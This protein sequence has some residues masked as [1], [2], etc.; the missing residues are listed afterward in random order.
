[1][2]L[3][4]SSRLV[5]F[6]KLNIGILDD[7]QNKKKLILNLNKLITKIYCFLTL[8]IFCYSLMEK[9]I[10]KPFRFMSDICQNK[11]ALRVNNI[12]S[13]CHTF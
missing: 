1:M 6:Q 3:I 9:K 13:Q 11:I 4:V 10:K 8:K 12:T 2:I 5:I 7:S